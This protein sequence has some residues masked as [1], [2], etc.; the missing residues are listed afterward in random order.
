[1]TGAPPART[2]LVL[3]GI[4]GIARRNGRGGDSELV[5]YAMPLVHTAVT[6]LLLENPALH[7]HLASTEAKAIEFVG[8][9]AAVCRDEA[10]LNHSD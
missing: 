4:E 2:L 3:V 6:S 10:L 5:S 9:V 7:V 8:L 1:M